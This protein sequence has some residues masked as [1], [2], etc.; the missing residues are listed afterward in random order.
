[1]YSYKNKQRDNTEIWQSK[2][3]SKIFS[4][5]CCWKDKYGQSIKEK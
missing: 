2:F 4:S 5:D 1:M 3:K